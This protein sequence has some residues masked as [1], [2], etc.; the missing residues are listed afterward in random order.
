MAGGKSGLEPGLGEM[1]Q[2]VDLVEAARRLNVGYPVAYR[3]VLTGR[4]KGH[5]SNGRWMV[6]S[7]D[8]RRLEREREE[9]PAV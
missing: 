9:E 7:E 1:T 6:D 3:L 4:L 8:L 2:T 5:R